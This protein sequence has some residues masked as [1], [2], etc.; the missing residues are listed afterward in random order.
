M[1]V[2]NNISESSHYKI[3]IIQENSELSKKQPDYSQK[4]GLSKKNLFLGMNSLV[5]TVVVTQLWQLLPQ[6]HPKTKPKS[7]LAKLDEIRP[8]ERAQAGPWWPLRP[9]RGHSL[10]QY[11]L[12]ELLQYR[13]TNIGLPFLYQPTNYQDFHLIILAHTVINKMTK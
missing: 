1:K 13:L 2:Y 10:S 6:Q 3:G 7:I 9:C 12:L 11:S 8:Q 4:S 5:V